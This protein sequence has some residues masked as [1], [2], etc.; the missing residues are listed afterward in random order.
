LIP[1]GGF[2]FLYSMSLGII[3]FTKFLSGVSRGNGK[4]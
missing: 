2:G 1:L 4:S 3:S